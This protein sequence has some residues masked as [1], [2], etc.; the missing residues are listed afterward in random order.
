VL[1]NR[2]LQ[3]TPELVSSSIVI[4]CY[5]QAAYAIRSGGMLETDA[6]IVHLPTRARSLLSVIASLLGVMLFGLI[7]WGSIDGL[8]YAIESGEYEGEGAL[9]VPMWPVRLSVLVGSGL[10]VIAYCLLAFRHL[11]AARRGEAI[12]TGTWH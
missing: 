1:L 8:A 9:R 4:I 7:F 11:A 5:L 6:L 10:A 12:V 3:G 2:P